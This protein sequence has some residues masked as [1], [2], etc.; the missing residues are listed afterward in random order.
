LAARKLS[1]GKTTILISHRFSTVSMAARIFVM[2]EVRII[3]R[4]IH[5]ELLRLDGQ[6]ADLYNLHQ[7]Q[8]GS[9]E[10]Q[11]QP[12]DPFTAVRSGQKN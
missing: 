7:R 2:D 10:E 6:H 9:F 11:T 1:Q 8:T 4:G 5:H 3:E 12:Y